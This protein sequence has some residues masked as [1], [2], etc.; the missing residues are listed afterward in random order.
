MITFCFKAS[1]P[2]SKCSITIINYKKRQKYILL[3]ESEINV[4][5]PKNFCCYYFITIYEALK[6][7]RLNFP[8]NVVFQALTTYF[9]ENLSK[10]KKKKS[11]FHENKK[12]FSIL[13]FSM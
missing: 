1:N 3:A 9:N 7:K 5:F 4:Y 12:R 2:S 13:C 6:K 10:K 8:H 11:K